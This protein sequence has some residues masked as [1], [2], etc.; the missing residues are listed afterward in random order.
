TFV[1]FGWHLLLTP[2]Q[3]FFLVVSLAGALGGLLHS[4]RSLSTYVGERYLFRSWL[5]YYL[6]LP[7]VGAV[8]P[9]SPTSCCGPACFPAA[10]PEASPTPTASRASPPWSGCSPRRPWRSCRR[11]SR[12]CSPAPRR[13]PTP[14]ATC[15]PT[16]MTPAT[17]P[18]SRWSPP[19]PRPAARRAPRS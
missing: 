3:Q 17:R 13:T 1:Y 8:W 16:R 9:R 14:S 19:S 15:H 4:L 7:L 18:P 6:A 10:R 2:D 11:C 5:L 12:P